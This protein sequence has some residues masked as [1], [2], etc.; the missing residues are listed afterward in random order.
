MNEKK[1]KRIRKMI[2]AGNSSSKHHPISD[3]SEKKYEKFWVYFD[4][5]TEKFENVPYT[6]TTK[7]YPNSHPRQVY[8]SVK[9]FMKSPIAA[10]NMLE[11]KMRH[12]VT[13][14]Q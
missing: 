4:S 10:R 11:M 14:P 6:V 3:M 9:R 12:E 8:L 13:Q 7:F 1:A 2:Y 5:K